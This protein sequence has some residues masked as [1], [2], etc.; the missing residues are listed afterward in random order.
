MPIEDCP[1]AN[2]IQAG[3]RFRSEG[4]LVPEIEEREA[5][6]FCGYRWSEWLNLP[7]TERSNSVAHYRLHYMIDAH[8]E[9]ARVE[10]YERQRRRPS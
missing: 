5:A 2:L 10:E 7:W 8:G 4:G 3:I 9:S 1:L 6:I